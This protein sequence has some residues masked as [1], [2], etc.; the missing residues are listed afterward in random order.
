MNT[1]N[2]RIESSLSRYF[3]TIGIRNTQILYPYRFYYPSFDSAYLPLD[4]L[5][6]AAFRGR[7]YKIPAWTVYHDSRPDS[8]NNIKLG[9]LLSE[10]EYEQVIATLFDLAGAKDNTREK[11]R[12]IYRHLHQVISHH[13]REKKIRVDE[14]ISRLSLA[15]S[16]EWLTGYKT[17]NPTWN[18]IELRMV[19]HEDKARK[20]DVLLFLAQCKNAALWM[21]QNVNSKSLRFANNGQTY[22]LLDGEHL[23]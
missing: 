2:E 6:A 17:S 11:R 22:Y 1:D 19:K 8:L 3:N 4:F 12:P 20:E 21:Q 16:L 9:V 7:P 15:E 5:K 10:E 13:L 14:R 23:P 18:R